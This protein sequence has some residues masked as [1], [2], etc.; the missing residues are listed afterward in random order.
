MILGKG[1]DV[2]TKVGEDPGKG[3]NTRVYAKM[4]IGAVRV[5]EEKVVEISVTEAA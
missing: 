5:E 1:K 3:F 4:A 2:T